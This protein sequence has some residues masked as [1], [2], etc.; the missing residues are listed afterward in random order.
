MIDS[1]QLVLVFV[2][3]VLTV[4]L[5]VLGIQV[6]FI[7][8]DLRRTIS[9]ANQVLENTGVITESITGPVAML[10]GL[11]SSLKAGSAIT[12]VKIIKSILSKDREAR[13]E[14][15]RREE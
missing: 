6:Y 1:V 9:K 10:S 13:Y 5:V 11:I 12:V 15:R 14:S 2:I 8:K 3:V 4:L 7:L